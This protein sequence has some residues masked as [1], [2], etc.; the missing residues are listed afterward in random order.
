MGKNNSSI[1][2]KKV[3]YIPF[4]IVLFAVLIINIVTFY[5]SRNIYM[6]QLEN[7]TENYAM[8]LADNIED[9]QEN[10][11]RIIDIM[12]EKM[13]SVGTDILMNKENID[14]QYLKELRDN[15]NLRSISWF[16]YEGET[17]YSSEDRF[18]GWKAEEDDPID[19]FIKSSDIIRIEEIRK[20]L[21]NYEFIK[22][23]FVRS[24]DGEFVQIVI[25]A[26]DIYNLVE[27][28]TYQ[29]TIDEFTK[30]ETV[31]YGYV[32]NIEK[33]MLFGSMY[34]MDYEKEK[35]NYASVIE[36][37]TESHITSENPLNMK[38]M[39]A[40]VPLKYRDRV[41]G[42]IVLGVSTYYAR[43]SM[44][45]VCFD[46][47]VIGVG[48]LL[49]F[50]MFIRKNLI[51]S[52]NELD[53]NLDMLNIEEQS[54]V[55][56]P[57]DDKSVFTGIYQT[58]NGILSRV[59]EN[60]DKI[61]MLDKK[62]FLALKESGT[63]YWEY[64]SIKK[65][66]VFPYGDILRNTDI[67][68]EYSEISLAEMLNDEMI[69]NISEKALKKIQYAGD[70]IQ[71][72]AKLYAKNGKEVW[73]Y[74]A[75]IKNVDEGKTN[76]SGICIDISKFKEQEKHIKELVYIDEMTSLYNGRYFNEKLRERLFGNIEGT[77]VLF[78][79]DSFN[80]LNNIKGMVFG[81][82]VL[83]K[84]ASIVE[85]FR[86]EGSFV[87]R[88]GE[89][90]FAIL[91][92]KDDEEIQEFLACLKREFGRDIF[93]E[94]EYVRINLSIGI[95]LFGSSADDDEKIMREADMAMNKAKSKSR[96][97][98][99]YL[100][101][102]HDMFSE[103]VN[104]NRITE[105]LKYSIKNDG[106][107]LL[108]QPQINSFTGYIDGFEALIRLKNLIISPLEFISIAE[109][110]GLINFIG[111]WVFEESVSQISIWNKHGFEMKPVA[112]NMSVKQMDDNGFV[113]FMEKI[114]KKYK[115]DAKYV[116][117]EITENLLIE[118]T[119]KAID[120]LNR[121]KDI[122]MSLALDDF[123]SGFS[124]ISYLTK[125]PVDKI[126]YD[127][128]LVDQY[129]DDKNCSVIQKLNLL[130]EEFNIKTLAEGVET[131]EQYELLRDAGCHCIQGYYFSKPLEPD[132]VESIYMKNFLKTD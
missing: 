62:F 122:G 74:L 55:M 69:A 104:S 91:M 45:L 1:D 117:I 6:K 71:H 27:K 113:E 11:Y 4:L 42:V 89:D 61:L 21:D 125:F 28:Y 84:I 48:F 38:V 107:K 8:M 105:L 5:V 53:R 56:M 126:K 121:I 17:V 111:R 30:E 100:Y 12:D 112:V 24:D 20:S 54:Y 72:V 23:V 50:Y 35:I 15:F 90:E 85:S 99:N 9:N 31:L 77:V 73:V 114:L 81:N 118:D 34:D 82:K 83:K 43:T 127:K 129:A 67:N 130:A 119:N 128:S 101:F 120:L 26:E 108:Y 52:L 124:S 123:G 109:K 87:S 32:M 57:E 33:D 58:L 94:D 36:G 102:K 22:S 68:G 93:V 65:S 98:T 44:W 3:I 76:Y 59:Y 79:V 39:E 2:R 86:P 70:N 47:F 29:A 7:Y 115:V 40:A 88:L 51:T 106:F 132:K 16:N 75:L 60:N 46:V 80:E 92:K 41:V 96:N 37:N 131:P 116:E 14:N 19:S 13:I 110:R 66:L 25:N 18:I 95:A 103:I 78:D 63:V 10:L 97:N 49:I 64:D